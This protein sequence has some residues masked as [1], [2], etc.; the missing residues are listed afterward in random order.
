MNILHDEPYHVPAKEKWEFDGDVTAI[1]DNML[2]RSIPQYDVMRKAITDLSKLYAIEN[3]KILDL[4]CSRGEV[5]SL[6]IG[7]LGGY[8]SY[9]GLDVSQPMLQAAR[10]RFKNYPKSLVEIRECDL[11][12]N[13]PTDFFSVVISCLTIQFTPIEYRQKILRNIYKSLLPGG[14]FIF[15]EK[16]LGDTAEVNE[17]LV[18]IYY[19]L[20]T[21]AGY[22]IEEI[23]RKRLSLEGVLVP[24]TARWNTDLLKSTGFEAIDCFWRWMNFAGWIAIK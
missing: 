11:R 17:N 2:R 14:A 15:V 7:S 6:L 20:K 19:D 23:E 13:Y 22:S 16:V 5:I 21:D 9:L 24:V 1:F 18:K 10:E 8:C 4:G 12:I 3:T